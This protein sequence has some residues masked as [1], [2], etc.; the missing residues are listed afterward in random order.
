[1][2]HIKTSPGTSN[3]L[4]QR[5]SSISALMFPV[6]S[7]SS[8]PCCAVDNTLCK[9]HSGANTHICICN[10]CIDGTCLWRNSTFKLE[11]KRSKAIFIRSDKAIKQVQ[12]CT[13][14]RHLVNPA[15]SLH[16]KACY[17]CQL[18][19]SFRGEW[20]RVLTKLALHAAQGS[21]TDQEAWHSSPGWHATWAADTG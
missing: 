17:K 10:S 14:W 21:L 2:K 16:Y 8:P 12:L 4:H 9:F 18:L 19:G 6:S 7:L 1:M 20:Q 5:L 11:R 13:W 15:Q 3:Y